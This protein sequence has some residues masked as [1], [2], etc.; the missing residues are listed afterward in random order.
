MRKED[1]EALIELRDVVEGEVM[2]G[3]LEGAPYLDYLEGCGEYLVG[4]PHQGDIEL[5]SVLLELID[6]IKESIA[7]IN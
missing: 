3:P 1:F 6:R 2:S 7:K 4:S 5:G